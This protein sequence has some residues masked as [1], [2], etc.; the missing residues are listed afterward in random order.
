ML[1][2]RGNGR[3]PVSQLK[4]RAVGLSGKMAAWM[5]ED[6]ERPTPNPD[7]RRK[8]L[9]QKNQAFTEHTAEPRCTRQGPQYEQRLRWSVGAIEGVDCC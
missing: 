3:I 8:A 1:L 5:Q 2:V 7:P 6:R 4:T 9:S